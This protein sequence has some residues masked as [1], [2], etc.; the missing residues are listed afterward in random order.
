MNSESQFS[1][2]IGIFNCSLIIT[3]STSLSNHA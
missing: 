1:E 2:I 3:Y